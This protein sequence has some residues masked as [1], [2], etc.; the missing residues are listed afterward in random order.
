VGGEAA[1]PAA[2]AEGKAEGAA[3]AAGPD[4]PAAVDVEMTAAKVPVTG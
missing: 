3:A 4:K 2:R 1:A